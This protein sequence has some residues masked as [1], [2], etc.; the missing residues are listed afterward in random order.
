MSEV[1]HSADVG[2]GG[3]SEG[4]ASGREPHQA[5]TWTDPRTTATPGQHLAARSL[6]SAVTKSSKA[7]PR[8]RNGL[9]SAHPAK[10]GHLQES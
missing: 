8:V 2:F 10:A 3:Y 6:T 7:V 4:E 9:S 1:G 5:E